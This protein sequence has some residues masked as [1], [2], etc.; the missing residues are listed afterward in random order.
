[1]E[2]ENN[3]AWKYGVKVFGIK[4]RCRKAEWHYTDKNELG[5]E[6]KTVSET[7][8]VARARAWIHQNMK[9]TSKAY[10]TANLW[11]TDGEFAN[12]EPFNEEHNL[13]WELETL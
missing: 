13:R 6:T 8:A 3:Q 1:M 11:T 12:W 7:E 9:T 10:A 2:L 4:K 5:P